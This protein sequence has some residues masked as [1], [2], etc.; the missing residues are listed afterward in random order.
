MTAKVCPC[1]W[2][3]PQEF[4]AFGVL[5]FT[6]AGGVRGYQHSITCH[7]ECRDKGPG[8]CTDELYADTDRETVNHEGCGLPVPKR[9]WLHCGPC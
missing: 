3:K 8:Y 1:Y 4:R 2:V 6:G 7:P 5:M 9:S